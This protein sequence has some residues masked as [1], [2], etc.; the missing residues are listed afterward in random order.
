MTTFSKLAGQLFDAFE[1]DTREDGSA[2][3]K[4]RDGSP[5]WMSD[6]V[7][8]AH[9]AVDE[10]PDDDV[11]SEC[12]DVA[13]SLN[14]CDDLRE[15]EERARE[16]ADEAV[17]VYNA[18]R[19]AWVAAKPGIRGPLCEECADDMGMQT[20]DIFQLAAWGWYEWARRIY[21]AIAEAVGEAA[22]EADEDEADED[23]D[24]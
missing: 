21:S 5:E 10:M 11:Y 22:D 15:A 7:R 23:E 17:S 16:Y 6:A 1:R 8:A 13:S 18:Q 12:R 3:Y 19:L 9:D 24:A 14:E 4:L 20:A 2:F